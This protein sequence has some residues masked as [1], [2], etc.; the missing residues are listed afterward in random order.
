MEALFGFLYPILWLAFIFFMGLMWWKIISKTGYHGALGI[1]MLVPVVNIVMMAVL[2]FKEWPVRKE[3][4]LKGIEIKFSAPLPTPAVVVMVI[5]AVF[6]IGAL[7]AAI[8]IPN[9]LKT[10]II[11]SETAA[12][13][14]VKTIINAV[15]A[16]S[17]ENKGQFPASEDDLRKG[18]YLSDPYN[19]AIKKGYSYSL[20][21]DKDNY[22][23][24]A[25]P[26][27][28]GTT[29]TKVF[30]A[31]NNGIISEKDCR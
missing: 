29:G 28:C 8:A 2:A 14:S 24:I 26:E 16:Y 27:V 19:N 23:I 4:K 1:L 5:C 9:Y 7:L 10:K 11:V 12:K 22:Q 15:E 21:F 30:I 6:F 18:N 20:N 13:A 25:T 17:S 31:D 3:M